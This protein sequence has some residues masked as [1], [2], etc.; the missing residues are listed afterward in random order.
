MS[1]Y[2]TIL[3]RPLHCTPSF[4]GTTPDWTNFLKFERVVDY[5]NGL[6]HSFSPFKENGHSWAVAG[7]SIISAMTGRWDSADIDVFA[8]GDAF[9][10][11]QRRLAQ[12]AEPIDQ[13]SSVDA[14]HQ[15]YIVDVPV[16]R[17][18]SLKATIDLCDCR[19][20][21]GIDSILDRFDFRV[22]R[23]AY[24]GYEVYGD[25]G[26]LGDLVSRTLTFDRPVSKYRVNKYA[27]RGFT[28]NENSLRIHGYLPDDAK[29]WQSFGLASEP[30]HLSPS[31][32][33]A[34]DIAKG[35]RPLRPIPF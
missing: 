19:D 32:R 6:S 11:L 10:V 33:I 17:G 8:W 20:D 3:D 25:T 22:C 13:Q 24:D 16:V 7:G 1:K 4:A 21:V 28:P 34:A 2:T 35:G 26:A 27:A 23:M 14:A 29:W 5:L 9:E 31:E 18:Y 30:V 12:H 15:K